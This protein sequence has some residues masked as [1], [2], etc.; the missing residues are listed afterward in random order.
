MNTTM[1][2]SY[3]KYERYEDALDL[4]QGLV[5]AYAFLR[6]RNHIFRKNGTDM[7]LC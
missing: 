2:S 5:S 3:P 7:E 6:E 1:I 4:K